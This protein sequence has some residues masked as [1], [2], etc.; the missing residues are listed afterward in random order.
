MQIKWISTTIAGLLLWNS[1]FMP[2]CRAAAA[3]QLHREAAIMSRIMTN[4]HHPRWNGIWNGSLRIIRI[5]LMCVTWKC[6]SPIKTGSLFTFRIVRAWLSFVNSPQSLACPQSHYGV[7]SPSAC[8]N[9]STQGDSRET[10][11]PHL[12]WC[13]KGYWWFKSS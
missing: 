10:Y 13:F 5:L 12:K 4:F 9:S 7:C 8:Y 1:A 6:E 2:L 3:S 11:V